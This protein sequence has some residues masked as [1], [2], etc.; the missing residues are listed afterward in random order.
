MMKKIFIAVLA[1]SMLLLAGCAN[2]GETTPGESKNVAPLE[3]SHCDRQF[4]FC[5]FSCV[6]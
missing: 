3:A 5:G 1:A 6:V 2:N 4:G